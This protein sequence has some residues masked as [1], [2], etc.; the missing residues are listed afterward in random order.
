MPKFYVRVSEV[1]KIRRTAV[2]CI[3]AEN[4]DE[5]PNAAIDWVCDMAHTIEWHE[6]PIDASPWE[7]EITM[8]KPD[9]HAANER[10]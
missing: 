5:A 1:L 10:E 4:E 2:I 6:D 8:L 3:E 9:Q 7:A